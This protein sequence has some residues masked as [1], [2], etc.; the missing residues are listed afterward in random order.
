MTQGAGAAHIADGT[1]VGLGSPEIGVSK[2]AQLFLKPDDKD[3]TY[4]K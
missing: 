1:F 4:G 3:G 2:V